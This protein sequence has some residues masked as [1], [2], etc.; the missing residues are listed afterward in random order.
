MAA[1]HSMKKLR[2][3]GPLEKHATARHALGFYNNLGVTGVYSASADSLTSQSQFRRLIYD[4]VAQVIAMHPSLSAVPLDED[5]KSPYFVRL[6]S[7]DLTRAV[8][9]LTRKKPWTSESQ[10]HDAELDEL[11]ERQHNLN[12]KE[13]LGEIPFWRLLIIESKDD[14]SCFVAAFIVHHALGDGASALAFHRSFLSA[15]STVSHTMATSEESEAVTR[16]VPPDVPLLPNLEALHPLK[17]TIPFIARALWGQWFPAKSR[18][19]WAGRAVSDDPSVRTT[20]MSTLRFSRSITNGLL[21]ASRAHSTTLTATIEVAIALALFAHLDANEYSTLRGNGT[22]GLRR[23]LPPDVIDDDS[24]GT[25]VSRYVQDHHRPTGLTGKG[26]KNENLIDYFSWDESRS[27]K[28]TIA[29]ELAK[30]GTNVEIAL[31]RWVSDFHQFFNGCIGQARETG[32]EV[33]NL[34][35]M[36]LQQKGADNQSHPSPWTLGR[37]VFSQS[38]GVTGAAVQT[39]LVTGI[40]GE[41][42]IAVTWLEGIVDGQW[43]ADVLRSL[44]RLLQDLAKS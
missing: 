20:R 3:V 15:L 17:L 34:G 29:S 33:S 21:A 44:E 43:I 39:S 6:P 4:A 42:N 7:I 25:F 32:F 22:V 24:M 37:V 8:T 12:F 10:E 27:V 30:N 23:L 19:L 11:L 1:Q 14:H 18:G 26:A 2:L 28:A 36:K 13:S 9:F 35:I 31:L 38:A 16:I 5:T 40:D 41:L